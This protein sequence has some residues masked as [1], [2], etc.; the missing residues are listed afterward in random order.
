MVHEVLNLF[1]G[2]VVRMFCHVDICYF[3]REGITF[4]GSFQKCSLMFADFCRLG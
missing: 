4:T 3:T 1:D 2:A